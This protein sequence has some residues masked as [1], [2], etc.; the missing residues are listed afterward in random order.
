MSYMIG[1]AN[2][3]N[4]ASTFINVDGMT[5]QYFKNLG[6]TASTPTN[7]TITY[8]VSNVTATSYLAT[9]VI[10][11]NNMTTWT[12]PSWTMTWGLDYG[13]TI[14]SQTG[15]SATLT[16]RTVQL[17]ST[18]AASI[19]GLGTLSV[20]VTMKTTASQHSMGVII[21][22]NGVIYRTASSTYLATVLAQLPEGHNNTGTVTVG[23]VIVNSPA[24]S[25]L[26]YVTFLGKSA[27]MKN[28]LG[29]FTFPTGS[30]PT[31]PTQVTLMILIPYMEY[32]IGGGSLAA[33]NTFALPYSFSYSG[34]VATPTSYLWPANTSIG[35]FIGQGRL[36]RYRRCRDFEHD[37]ST[38]VFD[39]CAQQWR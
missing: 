10:R 31:S 34:G 12:A 32:V 11:N 7:V 36:D 22:F 20:T 9:V 5:T 17:T 23:D 39:I 37:M 3:T 19:A 16:G 35:F 21:G 6:A 25:S 38:L 14:K 24:D 18:S 30:P 29:Y 13:E 27:N 2:P 1:T 33:W 26:A 8:T 4:G 28:V 15:C